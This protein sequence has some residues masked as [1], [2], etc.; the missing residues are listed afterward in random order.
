MTFKEPSQKV[1]VLGS[2]STTCE[3]PL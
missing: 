1:F 3:K 2:I